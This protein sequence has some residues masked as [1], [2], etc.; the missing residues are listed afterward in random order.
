MSAATSKIGYASSHPVV[1]LGAK[2]YEQSPYLERYYHDDIVFGL[3]DN[4][5]C[6]LSLGG[7]PVADY[8]RLRRQVM[9]YDV[10][11]KPLGIKGPESFNFFHAGMFSFAGQNLLAT[12]TGWTREMGFEGPAGAAQSWLGQA[13][14]LRDKAGSE[15]EATVVSLPFFDPD[16]RI[17]RGLDPIRDDH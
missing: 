11:E 1:K 5:L 7:D 13:V 16:K 15:H 2:R 17:P 6:P 12:R 9:L 8:W 10:P 4:R 14:T 3:Y